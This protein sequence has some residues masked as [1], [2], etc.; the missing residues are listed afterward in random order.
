MA[1]LLQRGIYCHLWPPSRGETQLLPYGRLDTSRGNYCHL[2]PLCGAAR[3]LL[4]FMAAFC[5]LAIIA[6]FAA[7]LR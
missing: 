7:L 1:A 5:H 3:Q 4:P 2:W 6:C